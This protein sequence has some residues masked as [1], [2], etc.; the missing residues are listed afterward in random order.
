M[1][2]FLQVLGLLGQGLLFVI[3]CVSFVMLVV[4]LKDVMTDDLSQPGQES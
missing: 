2:I 4:S 3:G 1:D